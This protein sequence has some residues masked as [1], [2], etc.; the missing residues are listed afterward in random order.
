[1]GLSLNSD[2]IMQHEN[3]DSFTITG[4]KLNKRI[5]GSSIPTTT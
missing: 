3:N 1:M 2:S 4:G 5:S